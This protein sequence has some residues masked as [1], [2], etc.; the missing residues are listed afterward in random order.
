MKGSHGMEECWS[1]IHS[2]EGVTRGK[3][4]GQMR[5]NLAH[6]KVS[7]LSTES[8]CLILIALW[9]SPLWVLDGGELQQ[10]K[11]DTGYPPCAILSAGILQGFAGRRPRGRRKGGSL[12][13]PPFL[14]CLLASLCTITF[15]VV[16]T[17]QVLCGVSFHRDCQPLL[18]LPSASGCLPSVPNLLCLVLFSHCDSC[19][20]NCLHQIPSDSAVFPFHGEVLSGISIRAEGGYN[21]G[22]PGSGKSLATEDSRDSPCS[23]FNCA[24]QPLS[25]SCWIGNLV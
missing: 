1:N 6:P 24:G 16:S 2:G 15:A 3:S 10:Q 23:L 22:I 18:L 21:H 11:R 14:L 12:N 17:I 4:Q 5:K 7:A 20:T 13:T 19:M 9:L 25:T 8:A